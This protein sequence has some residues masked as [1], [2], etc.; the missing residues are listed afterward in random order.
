[1]Y[2]DIDECRVAV[3]ENFVICAQPN[4]QCLN[5][6]GSFQC[7]CVSGYESID[8]DCRRKQIYTMLLFAR[9]RN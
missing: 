1:M 9:I 4:T 8:G 2:I 5:S 6:D 3:L 7:V